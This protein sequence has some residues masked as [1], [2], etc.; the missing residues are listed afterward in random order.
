MESYLQDRKQYVVIARTGHHSLD[1]GVP[2][3]SILGPVLFSLYVQPVAKLIR[4]YG[5]NFHYYTDD[6]QLM[7]AFALNSTA[8]LEAL[9]RLEARVSEIQ[10][11]LTA[12]S[13][14]LNDQ[15]SKFLPIVPASAK[16]LVD[17]FAITVGGALIPVVDKVK[18]LSVYLDSRLDM[19]ASKS[20]IIRSCY[21]HLHHISQIRKFLPRK[22]RERV[23]N[24]LIMSRPDYCTSLLY[25]TMDNNSVGLQCIQNV[26]ARFIVRVPKSA[27]FTLVLRDLHWLPVDEGAHF[28]VLVLVHRAVN[29]GPMYLCDHVSSTSLPG[30]FGQLY[31]IYLSDHEQDGR[32]GTRAL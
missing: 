3:G 10:K 13:L 29:F 24:A 18:R 6:L 32:S 8:L 21:F 30:P 19:S 7:L 14:K 26:A 1:T 28:K 31:N 23:V 20:L 4:K 25:S 22:T 27:S 16:K 5:V 12:N 17:G 9:Q 2:Q 15:K 11:W